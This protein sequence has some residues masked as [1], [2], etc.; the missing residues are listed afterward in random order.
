MIPISSSKITNNGGNHSINFKSNAIPGYITEANLLV[1]P[2]NL[3]KTSIGTGQDL[4]TINYDPAK[5]SYQVTGR[6]TA[7]SWSR[8]RFL[9][10][11]SKLIGDGEI[12][13]RVAS[14]EGS[15]NSAMAGLHMRS[16]LSRNEP[17]ASIMLR[18]NGN[19]EFMVRPNWR[20]NSYRSHAESNV[21]AP[22]YL[23]L[24]RVGNDFSGFISED[25]SNW[26]EVARWVS[27]MPPAIDVGLAVLSGSNTESATATFDN[28]QFK[29]YN[30]NGLKGLWRFNDSPVITQ[31]MNQFMDKTQRL[32]M[33][34]LLLI[35]NVV[36]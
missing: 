7:I 28:F 33:L 6:G 20:Q 2:H 4:G 19:A 35:W 34:P 12:I 30:A 18:S 31:K 13:V 17:S 32:Q 14:L 23:R 10:G 22:Y 27:V 3:T 29:Q 1:S 25:A 9:F 5:D 24:V 15:G 21:S 26:T 11:S 16:S 8:D 36:P